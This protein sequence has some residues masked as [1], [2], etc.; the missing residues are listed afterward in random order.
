M[1]GQHTLNVWAGPSPPRP[2]RKGLV[3][4]CP[5]EPEPPTL[6]SVLLSAFFLYS[7]TG[8]QIGDGSLSVCCSL[9]REPG[10][11]L[12]PSVQMATWFAK[13]WAT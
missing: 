4:P 1:R 8:H 5:S 12:S 11:I 9:P 13:G 10:P 7:I 6:R 2:G 3:Q